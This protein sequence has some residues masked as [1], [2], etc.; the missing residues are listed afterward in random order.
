MERSE[1]TA[2]YL[3]ALGITVGASTRVHPDELVRRHVATLAFTSVGP[4]LGEWLPLDPAELYDR[5]VVRRRGGYCFEQNGLAFEVL[6]ELG[7]RP[8]IVL[9][10]VL[11]NNN[12][13]PGLTHRINV[14]ELDGVAHVVD[15]GFGAP[16]P[17]LPVPLGGEVVGS[18]WRRF[19]VVETQPGHWCMQAQVQDGWRPLYRFE[20]VDYGQTD[21]E[22]GHFYSHRHPRAT[23]VNALVASLILD[24]EVRSLRNRD[25]WV[26]R[27]EGE[28]QR[29]LESA[30]ELH[31]LLA[32][33]LDVRISI[34]EARRLL[35]TD[36]GL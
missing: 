4:Q 21:C 26:L 10:R 5:I 29:R 18:S 27:P 3:A 6:E 32:D 15:V 35:G 14:V 16:G 20:L 12:P 2:G 33:E 31:A 11:T 17:H 28:T 22:I 8:R 24:D 9:A 13:D 23:W 19:R 25:Y 1:L 36:A 34:E 7:W 30:D